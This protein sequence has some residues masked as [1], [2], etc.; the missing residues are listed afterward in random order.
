[1]AEKVAVCIGQNLYAPES[2]VRPLRGCV[3]D[4]L[5]IGELLRRAGFVIV[6]QLHDAAA[7]RDGIL[8]ELKMHATR[9]RPG[10]QLV[11]WNSSHGYQV[12]DLDGDEQ[13]DALDE[14]I[15]T[16]DNDV[17]RPLSDDKLAEVLAL[18]DPG[19]HVFVGSDSCHS[20]TLSRAIE[21]PPPLDAVPRLWDPPLE[22]Q[23]RMGRSSLDL[24]SY[25][26]RPVATPRGEQV[27]RFGSV[28]GSPAGHL[29]L[30]GCEAAQ[31]SWDAKYPQGYHGAMTYNFARAVLAA[32]ES[33]QAITYAAAHQAAVAGIRAD[34][35]VQD[36]QLEG[37]QDLKDAPVFG[38]V[39]R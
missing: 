26:D 33:G 19:A 24:S 32:W 30:A 10:D 22:L 14:A 16:Y 11:V 8:G 3:N 1:M 38:Y 9:L 35:L 13:P 36:P 29:L 34:K 39:P 7:T 6:R 37:A 31:V 5:L 20:G 17:R 27:W 12:P 15:C 18:A 2:G 23:S 25:I 21:P 28:A 4:A